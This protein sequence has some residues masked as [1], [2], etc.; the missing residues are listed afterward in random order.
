MLADALSRL[1][2]HTVPMHDS[3]LDDENQLVHFVGVIE[4]D[5]KWTTE[6][7]LPA[8]KSDC[9]TNAIRKL[10]IDE[11]CIQKCKVPELSKYIICD[12]VLFYR[13]T[14]DKPRGKEDQ[15]N[16]VVPTN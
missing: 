7:L 13:K 5:K 3:S 14:I 8:Q 6:Q 4:N 1:D 9:G 11:E 10:I 15:I 2:D 16:I 12:D